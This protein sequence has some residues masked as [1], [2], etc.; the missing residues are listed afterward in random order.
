MPS[1]KHNLRPARASDKHNLRPAR[2]T[3]LI[4]SL[5]NV[6]LH[7]SRFGPRCAFSPTAGATMLASWCYLCTPLI[8][9]SFFTPQP[10]KV[11]ICGRHVLASVQDIKIAEAL[12]MLCL[13]YYVM[14][15]KTSSTLLKCLRHFG[16]RGMG[17]A[18]HEHILR[19]FH[20]MA[21]WIAEMLFML[22]FAYTAV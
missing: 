2:A 6:A 10:H 9:H 22:F 17:H 16:F 7:F 11:M 18:F 15:Y 13:A 14:K 4:S 20:I 8:S 1:D 5:I 21:G 12:L 19:I 3:D